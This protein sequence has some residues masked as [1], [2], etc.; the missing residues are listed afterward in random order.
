MISH[1]TL[2]FSSSILVLSVCTVTIDGLQGKTL[3]SL[4][5]VILKYYFSDYLKV[6][7][8]S[9]MSA[10]S[11]YPKHLPFPL[12]YTFFITA[13]SS[14]GHAPNVVFTQM[15]VRQMW[16][17]RSFT[18][19]DICLHIIVNGYCG[20]HLTEAGSSSLLVHCLFKCHWIRHTGP[21]HSAVW[22]RGSCA[23]SPPL[24]E[25]L[26]AARGEKLLRLWYTTGGSIRGIVL[27]NRTSVNE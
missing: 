12:M 6:C 10:E 5:T 20:C 13:D 24:W 19:L 23:S 26:G 1:K 2:V 22:M 15:E 25:S 8:H 21:I 4:Q 3:N 9:R 17:K 18:I 11:F 16:H 14:K 27:A 7:E